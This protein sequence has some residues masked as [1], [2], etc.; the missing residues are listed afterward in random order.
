MKRIMLVTLVLLAVLTVGVVSATEKLTVNET[1]DSIESSVEENTDLLTVG[2][3]E[4]VE[5]NASDVLG[6]IDDSNFD[7]DSSLLMSDNSSEN[8]GVSN[9]DVLGK[10]KVEFDEGNKIDLNCFPS[11]DII[12]PKDVDESNSA[13][14]YVDGKLCEEIP[15][16]LKGYSESID[17]D[18]ISCGKHSYKLVYK[19]TKH[20]KV[21]ETG[22]FYVDWS[23]FSLDKMSED[24]EDFEELIMGETYNNCVDLPEDTKGNVKVIVNNN[25]TYYFGPRDYK[26][27][28]ISDLPLG[29]NEILFKYKDSKYSIEK[30]L[31][32]IVKVYYKIESPQ[33]ISCMEN[34]IFSLTLPS[35]AKGKL[36]AHVD[37][38]DIYSPLV[39]GSASITLPIL[40]AGNH[41]IWIGYVGDDYPVKPIGEDYDYSDIS[42]GA[43]V[44]FPTQMM[45]H[46]D[47]YL[48]FELPK[49]ANGTLN[50]KIDGKNKNANFI[51][52]T[53]KVSLSDLILGQH[54]ISI[55][56][57]DDDKYPDFEKEF[58]VFV[59][60]E[61]ELFNVVKE[62][63]IFVKDAT[64]FTFK[65]PSDC[66]GNVFVYLDGKIKTAKF[67]NGIATVSIYP[68]STGS[69]TVYYRYDFSYNS[70]WA[71]FN[72]NV[73]K[74]P[75]IEA[76]EID[77]DYP[78]EDYIY[79]IR[80]LDSNK[81]PVKAGESIKVT[82]TGK[83][84]NL[85][86]K[87]IIT[88]NLKTDKNGYVYFKC[89]I[90]KTFSGTFRGYFSVN[91]NGYEQITYE[92]CSGYKYI[93]EEVEITIW[94]AITMKKDNYIY[95]PGEHVETIK[96]S[97][98]SHIFTLKI[99]DGLDEGK[100]KKLSKIKNK[101]VKLK[102]NGK[103]YSAK[104]NS[105]C[106]VKFT[107][108][109]SDLNKLKV[110]KKYKAQI[111]YY[112]ETATFTAKVKK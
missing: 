85:N 61:S 14:F 49:D 1:L 98:K 12:F 4:I 105:N 47:E 19:N 51:N 15:F 112:K 100:A 66:K 95:Y 69:R 26:N 37:G 44:K 57:E 28:I 64:K 36:L 30:T 96:K 58:D 9:D 5:A 59:N 77:M 41:N 31:K 35:D 70:T 6:Q 111:I 21:T 11:V 94:P 63:I 73:I 78:G 65:G 46:D 75:I 40:S 76:K 86:K 104:I 88:K 93:G 16:P 48:I 71:K 23:E 54:K 17:L 50:I 39:N 22:T 52:G 103:T 92:D 102:L 109:K 84:H 29:T 53:A 101:V 74:G 67:T 42:V 3:D 56:Y 34:A 45:Y 80:I 38:E 89:A 60:Y 2:N 82:L 13:Y 43:N 110:G 83:Y 20:K 32:H 55:K 72:I 81:K 7:D 24:F 27:I 10:A 87:F 68:P 90:T 108:K 107:I 18:K 91:Y 99:W 62:E 25:K 33:V 8:I 106:I 79:K 97:A